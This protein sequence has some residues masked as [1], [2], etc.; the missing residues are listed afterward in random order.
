MKTLKFPEFVYVPTYGLTGVA[1][2]AG[3]PPNESWR[4]GDYGPNSAILDTSAISS[5]DMTV[6]GPVTSW[7]QLDAAELA[8]RAIILHERLY[9]QQPGILVVSP[10]STVKGKSPP[11]IQDGG[12]VIYPRYTE[13]QAIMDVLRQ[14]GASSY[15]VYSTWIYVKDDIP[16][17]GHEFWLRNY[18][19]LRSN[20]PDVVKQVFR[21]SFEIDYFRNSYFASPKAI[22]AGAY[23]G[24]AKDRSYETELMR[25]HV[26][27]MPEKALKLF[28]ENWKDNVSG[29]GVGLNIRLGPFLS[30]VLSR[31]GSRTDI[32]NVVM[33]LREE[34]QESREEFWRL[35]TE[36]LTE[37]RAVVAIR[38]LR[39][40][41]RAIQSI[42]PASFR[43]KERPFRFL[44][45][46]TLAVADIAQTGGVLSAIKFAGDILLNRDPHLAQVSTIGLTKKL[47]SE[48][49]SI[50]DSLVQQLRR[51]FSNQELGALG[52]PR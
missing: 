22:G 38:K 7:D 15:A 4:D 1:Y 28:D 51:H 18:G 11:V 32:P 9:W 26:S 41:E 13:P 30:I 21:E 43:L 24:S 50:D 12:H 23:F 42:V 40:I 47:V 46:T 14:S 45:D 8:I 6:V 3:I 36:P 5:L 35:F 29:E 16:V 27:A 34:F 17:E 39:N 2:Q 49:K 37:K 25:G 20:D 10:E 44:W 48:L 19:R 52:I 33:E 31:A